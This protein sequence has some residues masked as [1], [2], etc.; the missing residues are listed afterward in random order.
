MPVWLKFFDAYTIRARVFPAIIAAIPALAMVILLVS[1]TGLAC[2]AG[3][4]LSAC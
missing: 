2:R 4:P 1:W 3:S